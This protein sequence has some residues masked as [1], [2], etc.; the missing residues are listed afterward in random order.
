MNNLQQQSRWFENLLEANSD[1]L[2]LRA[3]DGLSGIHVQA[4]QALSD[5]PVP[6]RRQES[7]RYSDLGKLYRQ[8]F[9]ISGEAFDALQETDI[10]QWIYPKQDSYRLVMV[11]GQLAAHLSHVSGLDKRITLDGISQL[12]AT[13]RQGVAAYLQQHGGFADDTFGQINRALMQ[14]GFYLRVPQN[15]V[16]DKPIE[17]VFVNLSH[18]E[19]LLSQPASLIILEPGA[20]AQVVERYLSLGSSEYFFNGMTDILLREHA[21]LRHQ[22]IQQESSQAYHLSRVG[23]RQQAASIYQGLTIASGG[24]WSR[25]DIQVHLDG[26]HAECDLQGVYTVGDGQYNDI[27]LDVAHNAADC[28][29]QENFRGVVHGRGKAVFDGRILVA[30]DAQKTDAQ[31][32]NKNLLLVE[33]AEVNTKPQ[34]EIYADDVKCSHGTTV[35]KVNPD[36]LFYLRARGIDE[37]QAYRMLCLGFADQV[38]ASIEDQAVRQHVHAMFNRLL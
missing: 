30:K 9:R 18:D 36:Q 28:R 12:S 31:L 14:D 4:Q 21:E 29:S 15:T 2:N 7:W 35:G 6:D 10:D 33:D 1:S 11:N 26:P 27:H 23:L 3:A 13:E 34:L 24:A 38:L 22:R 16:V 25:N 20:R 32:S 37:Q 5:L 17:V 19:Q 8:M